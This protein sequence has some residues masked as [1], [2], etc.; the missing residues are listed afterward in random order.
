[1]FF[2]IDFE[3]IFDRVNWDFLLEILKGRGFSDKWI[4]WIQQILQG[5]RTC[6]NF[7]GHL[8]EYFTCKIGVRHGLEY[9]KFKQPKETI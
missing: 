1:V 5:I 7:N 2:K 6:I 9:L 4:T 3:K 8:S